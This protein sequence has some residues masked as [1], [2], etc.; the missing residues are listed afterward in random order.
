MAKCYVLRQRVSSERAGNIQILKT[1]YS[2]RNLLILSLIALISQVIA[3]DPIDEYRDIFVPFEPTP[4]AHYFFCAL[5]L[6]L[7]VAFFI[8][9]VLHKDWW[10]L[11]LPIGALFEGIGYPNKIRFAK[12]LSMGLFIAGDVFILLAPVA[13]LAFNYLVFGR[14]SHNIANDNRIVKEKRNITIISP[15]AIK[16]VFVWSD[17]LTFLCQFAGQLMQI[18]SE[19]RPNGNKVTLAGMIAQ[20]VSYLCFVCIGLYCRFK[21]VPSLRMTTIGRDIDRVLMLL[22]VSSLFILI[23]LLYRVIELSGGSGNSIE[24][25]E[26]CFFVLDAAPMVIAI[27]VWLYWPSRIVPMKKSTSG[28]H[29]LEEQ[30]NTYF[31]NNK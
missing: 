11:C 10:A 23:R 9:V 4:G 30:E 7:C 13:Y 26:A 20:F 3:Q 25:S 24:K 28:F 22:S 12:S 16:H 29:G 21:A 8:Y 27:G 5:Y 31:F 17:I 19:Q 15:R 6:L 18:A 2:F 14:L 1:M